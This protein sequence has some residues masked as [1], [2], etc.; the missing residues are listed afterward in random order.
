MITHGVGT[1]PCPTCKDTTPYAT[2]HHASY[3][4][5]T[6][7][8]ANGYTHT[9]RNLWHVLVTRECLVCGTIQ[10]ETF[11]VVAVP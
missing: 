8:D 3:D 1:R 2:F 10:Q 6:T 11:N 4:I 5:S 9:T 7:R